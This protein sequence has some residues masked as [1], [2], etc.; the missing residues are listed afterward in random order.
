MDEPDSVLIFVGDIAQFFATRDAA[1]RLIREHADRHP[2][3]VAVIFNWSGVAAVTGAFAAEFAAWFLRTGRRTGNQGMNDDVRA[4]YET[5]VQRLS[6]SR[7]APEV[8]SGTAN[9]TL[10]LVNTLRDQLIGN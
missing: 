8:P 5:A 9:R 7:D 1:R 2:E 4:T 3:R 10:S 6:A